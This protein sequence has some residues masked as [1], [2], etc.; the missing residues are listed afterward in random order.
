[1]VATD[2]S[3]DSE[4]NGKIWIAAHGAEYIL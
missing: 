2:E 4:V 3:H 1:M